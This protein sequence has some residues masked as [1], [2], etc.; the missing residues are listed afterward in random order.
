MG[1]AQSEDANP[2]DQEPKELLQNK[3][4]EAIVFFLFFFK[5]YLFVFLG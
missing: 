5:F 1:S 2:V 3:S 4:K